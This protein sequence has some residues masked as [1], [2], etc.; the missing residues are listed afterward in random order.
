MTVRDFIKFANG[1]IYF[2]FSFIKGV[3]SR[4]D[5]EGFNGSFWTNILDHTVTT[6]H[7]LDFNR[8]H[9]VC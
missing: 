9:I 6:Y 4:D 8:I 2:S 7:A 3:Y 1:D 5:L